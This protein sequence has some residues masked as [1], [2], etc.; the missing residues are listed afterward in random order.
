MTAATTDDRLSAKSDEARGEQAR[1]DQ[2]N[3]EQATRSEHAEAEQAGRDDEPRRKPAPPSSRLLWLVLL[4]V[5]V[6]L[7]IGAVGHWRTY[8]AAK[9][10]Q[11]DINNDVP[12]VRTAPAKLL[13][14]P[15]KITLPGQTQGFDQANIFARATGYIAQR[16]VDIGSLVK[17]GDL[18]VKI[19]SPDLDRQ[20]DQAEAQLSQMNAAL[21]QAKAQVS[22]SEANLRLGNVTFA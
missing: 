1:S 9:E 2:V 8:A 14:D 13:S 5:T 4:V 3:A 19:A 17:Q 18:L 7:A 21:G 15:I 20:L 16:S 12:S 6:A 10:T 11:D 22:L